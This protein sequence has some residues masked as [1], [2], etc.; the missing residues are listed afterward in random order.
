[1]RYEILAL[2]FWSFGNSA[3]ILTHSLRHRGWL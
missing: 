1:M 3:W 2:V